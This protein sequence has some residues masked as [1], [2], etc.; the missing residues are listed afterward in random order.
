MIVQCKV[1]ILFKKKFY[2]KKYADVPN[3]DYIKG[4]K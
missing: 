3:S 1:I 4:L 2:Y